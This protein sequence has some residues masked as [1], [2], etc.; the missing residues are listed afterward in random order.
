M[1][2]LF[3]IIFFCLCFHLVFIFWNSLFK[4]EKILLNNFKKNEIIENMVLFSDTKEKIN[5]V[6]RKKFVAKPKRVKKRSQPKNIFYDKKIINSLKNISKEIGDFNKDRKILKKSI[7]NFPKLNFLSKEKKENF[8]MRIIE[9]MQQ[10]LQ[11][12]EDGEVK[13]NFFILPNGKIENVNIIFSQSKKNEEYLK[14]K[15]DKISFSW[16]KKHI[17]KKIEISAIFM[18]EK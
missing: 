6:K 16:I 11:F 9:E 12:I 18:N 3:K 2:N 5:T 13:V 14:E 7:F 1:P 15:L 17:K 10:K 4:R 8:K